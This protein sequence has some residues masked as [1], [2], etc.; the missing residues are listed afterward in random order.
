[1]Q[2]SQGPDSRAGEHQ[3]REFTR[4]D[5]SEIYC[6]LICTEEQSS[7]HSILKLQ[8]MPV[9]VLDIS[10]TGVG[11]VLNEQLSIGTVV[12]MNMSGHGF[13]SKRL[14]GRV[15]RV[16]SLPEGLYRAGVEVEEEGQASQIAKLMFDN[17]VTYASLGKMSKAVW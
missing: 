8:N 3:Y 10:H 11:L 6:E 9:I 15:K 13:V 1:M 12:V 16:Q 17:I 4:Y 7:N 2:A 5:G 14:H